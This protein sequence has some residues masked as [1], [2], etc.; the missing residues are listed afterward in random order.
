MYSASVAC[1]DPEDPPRPG[2]RLVPPPA[3][4]PDGNGRAPGQ[5]AGLAP[6]AVVAAA[7]GVL[8]RDGHAAL[9]MR[10]VAAE[11]GVAPN[12]LYSHVDGKAALAAAVLDA[13]LGEVALPRRGTW[14]ARLERQLAATRCA[15]QPH[16]ELVALVL[17][18]PATGPHARRLRAAA[19]AELRRGGVAEARAEV[20]VEALL[21]HAVAG[22]TAGDEVFRSGLRWLLDGLLAA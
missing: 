20:A 7:L 1:P 16:P 5:R 19:L 4:A 21:L 22:A 6:D 14:R 8:R 12:A 15:L 10:R 17:G 11:L 9:S 3:P 13:V 18:R 2:L